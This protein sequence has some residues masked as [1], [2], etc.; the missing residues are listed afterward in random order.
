MDNNEIDNH[1]EEQARIQEDIIKRLDLVQGSLNK[2]E[3]GSTLLTYKKDE[4]DGNGGVKQVTQTKYVN[5][6]DVEQVTMMKDN[7]EQV[8]ELIKELSEVNFRLVELGHYL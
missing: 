5:K 1:I 4:S 2:V 7:H 3:N 6:E 8:K